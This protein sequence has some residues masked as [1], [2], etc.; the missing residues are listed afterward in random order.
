MAGTGGDVLG[1]EFEDILPTDPSAAAA[2]NEARPAAAVNQAPVGDEFEDILPSAPTG[3]AGGS[4]P[5]EFETILPSAVDVAGQKA[6]AAHVAAELRADDA[7]LSRQMVPF[8]RHFLRSFLTFLLTFS[9]L[10]SLI[11]RVFLR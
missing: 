5:E 2:A 11:S 6:V 10:L 4:N 3:S 7:S 8:L 9:V 1:D